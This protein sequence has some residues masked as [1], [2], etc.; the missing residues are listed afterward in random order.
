MG[1]SAGVSFVAYF[2]YIQAT[3]L[4]KSSLARVPRSPQGFIVTHKAAIFGALGILQAVLFLLFALLGYFVPAIGARVG[5]WVPTM[6]ILA[7]I[8]PFSLY[9]GFAVFLRLRRARTDPELQRQLLFTNVLLAV[10][11]VTTL[12]LAVIEITALLE[13][14]N[15]ILIELVWLLSA[16]FMAFAFV[17]IARR[18]IRGE[19]SPD[20]QHPSQGSHRTLDGLNTRHPPRG[21]SQRTAGASSEM[22]MEEE[23]P[24]RETPK[25]SSQ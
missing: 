5:F 1:T 19:V 6:F 17:L 2:A 16:L 20:R 23:T 15:Y 3:V 4:D 12:I 10:L 14:A 8:L 22:A 9:L 24:Q 13:S 21:T 11:N 7:T 18:E 25:P